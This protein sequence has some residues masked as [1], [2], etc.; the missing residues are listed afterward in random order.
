MFDLLL[1]LF[2]YVEDVWKKPN[3][4]L[5]IDDKK[6]KIVKGQIYL[7]CLFVQVCQLNPISFIINLT[8]MA[9]VNRG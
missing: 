9:F 5:R 3:C 2:E 7:F 1:V 6:D 4:C 8:Q